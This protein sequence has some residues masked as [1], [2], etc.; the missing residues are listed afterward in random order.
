MTLSTSDVAVCCSSAS[1]SLRSSSSIFSLASAAGGLRPTFSALRCF[2]VLRRCVFAALPP[3]LSRR[4]IASP[5]AQD[6]AW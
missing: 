3:A 6:R 2:N 5:E 4:L 1:F